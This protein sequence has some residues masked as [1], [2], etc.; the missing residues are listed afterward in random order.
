MFASEITTLQHHRNV[1]IIILSSSSSLSLL[2]TR[3]MEE[4]TVQGFNVQFKD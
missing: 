2:F 4:R 1:H 3:G